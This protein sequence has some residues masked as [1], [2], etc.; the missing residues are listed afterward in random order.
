MNVSQALQRFEDLPFPA[1][2]EL[3]SLV[4]TIGEIFELREGAVLRTDH[5]AG[6]PVTLQVGG[7]ELAAADIVVVDDSLSIRITRLSENT[8]VSS[9]GNGIS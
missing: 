6:A 3:G 9:G 5:P 1:Q 8:K 4:M 2:V 7:I